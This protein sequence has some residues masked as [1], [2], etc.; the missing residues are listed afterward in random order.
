MPGHSAAPPRIGQ[1]RVRRGYA[2]TAVLL[3]VVFAFGAWAVLF[4]SCG[5]VLRVEEARALRQTRSQWTAPAMAQALRLLQTGDPPAED[6]ACK[7]ALAQDGETRYFR[8]SY[9]KIAP[10]RW[11][12]TAA[13]T[14][15]DDVSPDAPATFLTIPG[16]PATLNASPNSSTSMQ[17]TWSDVPHDTGYEVER[18]PNGSNTWTQ[19]GTTGTSVVAYAD[20]TADPATTYYYRVRAVN[21]V[22]TGTYS[23]TASATTPP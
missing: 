14:D 8:L 1:P 4:H 7:L 20:N 6:Y 13:I 21:G 3:F 16:V 10:I 2:L 17:L 15:A 23:D 18:S 22:G 9:E 5:S 19:I 11:T 12:V